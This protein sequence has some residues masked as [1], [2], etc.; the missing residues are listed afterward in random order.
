MRT[1]AKMKT[2]AAVCVLLLTFASIAQ[3]GI[4][5]RPIDQSGTP[6]PQTEVGEPD[7]GHNGLWEYMRQVIIAAQL[8]STHLR[9]FALPFAKITS[10]PVHNRLIS[11]GRR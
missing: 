6:S 11:E 8:G 9:I 7:T 10:R 5:D 2:L 3:A 4:P 1:L